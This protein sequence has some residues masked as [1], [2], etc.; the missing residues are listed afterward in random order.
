M[1]REEQIK[2]ATNVTNNSVIDH[3]SK[4][5]WNI[6]KGYNDDEDYETEI[7]IHYKK[8]EKDE[9]TTSNSTDPSKS[10]KNKNDPGIIELPRCF[11]NVK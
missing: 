10:K 7:Q 1:R 2:T 8:H 5:D 3:Y 6:D 11:I 9:E 4:S